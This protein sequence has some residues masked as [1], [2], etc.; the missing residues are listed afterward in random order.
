MR[1]PALQVAHTQDTAL[2]F[3]A[4]ELRDAERSIYKSND[5]LCDVDSNFPSKDLY[6]LYKLYNF[7]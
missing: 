2:F 1:L 7:E 4:Y 5:V 6:C 3:L